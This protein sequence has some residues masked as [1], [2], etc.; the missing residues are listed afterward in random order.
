MSG[1][2]H[3]LYMACHITPLNSYEAVLTGSTLRGSAP[4][5]GPFSPV[6]GGPVDLVYRP[7]YEAAVDM[8]GAVAIGG[9]GPVGDHAIH[10]A[11]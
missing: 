3:P 2:N 10:R 4:T 7:Q 5:A 1:V 9:I 8:D 6:T 11:R